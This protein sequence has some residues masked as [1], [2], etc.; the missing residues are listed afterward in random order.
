[1]RTTNATDKN[2]IIASQFITPFFDFFAIFNIFTLKKIVQQQRSLTYAILCQILLLPIKT[3]LIKLL[4]EVCSRCFLLLPVLFWF[5]VFYFL[6]F[7]CPPISFTGSHFV[8]EVIFESSVM[9][10][11]FISFSPAFTLNLVQSKG[12]TNATAY[13]CFFL[14]SPNSGSISILPSPA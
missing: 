3:K 6:T 10:I 13:I 2:I 5:L 1:M 4:S 8:F 7:H 12:L 11:Q 9:I 14:K